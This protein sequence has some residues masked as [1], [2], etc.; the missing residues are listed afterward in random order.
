[1]KQSGRSLIV[2][3][4]ATAN[5]LGLIP[6]FKGDGAWTDGKKYI[7][8]PSL[9]AIG[10]EQQA[11][12]LPGLAVHEGMHVRQTDPYPEDLGAFGKRLCNAL[13]DIRNERDAQRLFP[14]AKAMLHE[15]VKAAIA[16]EWYRPPEPSDSQATT[17]DAALFLPLRSSELGHSVVDEMAEQYKE[18]ANQIFGED[19][20]NDLHTLARQATLA[21]NTAGVAQGV[22]QILARLKQE[23][24]QDPPP[25]GKPNADSE[26]SDDSDDSDDS[27]TSDEANG[28]D[29]TEDESE[30]Q[31]DSEASDDSDDSEDSNTSDEASGSD[32][33]E[34]ESE[35]QGDSEASDDSDDSDDSNT[36]DEA[37]GSDDTED[38]SEGQG[39]SEAS[40]DSDDSED[41]NT[42]DEASGSDDTEDGQQHVRRSKRV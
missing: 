22:R 13:E 21:C 5:A 25:P 18:L 27:N 1:M 12:L 23:M 16:I 2:L 41:S 17:L 37:N 20:M 31:G 7:F 26:A 33:T 36:S 39:D 42:S 28:S 34:D 10:T 15:T 14:G 8:F 3:A 29:D 35:G 4:Q 11:A 6:I 19:L 38:E 24:E 9:R 30:G 32:D 40:D